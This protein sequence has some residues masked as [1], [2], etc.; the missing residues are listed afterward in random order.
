MSKSRTR[1]KTT[2]VRRNVRKGGDLQRLHIKV[3][4]PRIVMHQVVSGLVKG[5]KCFICLLLLGLVFYGVYRGVEHL[6]IGNEK[7]R[8]RNIEVVDENGALNHGA[9]DAKRAAELAKDEEGNDLI[10]LH[11]TIFAVNVNRVQEIL[12]NLPEIEKCEVERRLPDTIKIT[13]TERVPKAWIK[14]DFLGFSDRAIGGVLIDEHGFTFPCLKT[15]LESAKNLPVIIMNKAQ[16]EDFQ[17]GFKTGSQDLM[18]T[19]DLIQLSN[20][21]GA[22]AEWL[23]RQIELTNDYSLTVICNDGVSA[24]FGM[25]DHQR[26]INDF[27]SIREHCL[28]KNR[29][30]KKMNLI[31]E[32]NI[33][34]EFK[35]A[36]AALNDGPV[37]VKPGLPADR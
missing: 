5:V 35:N 25:H 13:V 28:M 23:P 15:Q 18:I 9:L 36:T 14:C 3:N 4:S 22:R 16:G 20:E 37:L 8:L 34:V 1:K 11:K 33:P 27:I 29:Q 30:I 19:L 12:S 32:I 6:F 31:P 26:Q 24:V 21:A 2:P 17:H 10:D 7:Y